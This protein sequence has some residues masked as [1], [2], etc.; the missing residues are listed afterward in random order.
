M[1]GRSLLQVSQWLLLYL[2]VHLPTPVLGRQVE[3]IMGTDL[4]TRDLSSEEIQTIELVLLELS[5][6]PINLNTATR[7]ILEQI[8]LLA[9]S[10]VDA[11][12]DFRRSIWG[13][14][15]LSGLKEIPG[16]SSGAVELLSAVGYVD[17]ET[18]SPHRRASSWIQM[19][20]LVKGKWDSSESSPANG[21]SR[22]RRSL[23][24]TG[25][26]R[27]VSWG[28]TLQNDPYEQFRWNPARGWYG[29]DHTSGYLT[30]GSDDS[31][32]VV[33]IGNF[34]VDA[35]QG[36]VHTRLFGTRLSAAS[37]SQIVRTWSGLRRYTG[38]SASSLRG[39]GVSA[40]LLTGLRLQAFFSRKA[41]D[42]RAD[43]ST[44]D[45]S[46]FFVLSGSGTHISEG[47]LSR[48]KILSSTVSGALIDWQIGLF[49]V[50]VQWS[51]NR[52]QHPVQEQGGEG[53]RSQFTAGSVYGMA[54]MNSFR[55]IGE[56]TLGGNRPSQFVLGITWKPTRSVRFFSHL[57][58]YDA[59]S[60]YRFGNPYGLRRS[61]NFQRG[62]TIG[63]TFR[64]VRD[65]SFSASLNY[66]AGSSAKEVA[67][68]SIVSSDLRLH[69]Q[70]KLNPASTIKFFL[71][72][73]Q[74][75]DSNIMTLPSGSQVRG[76][77]IERRWQASLLVTY[78]ISQGLTLSSRFDTNLAEN[79]FSQ[80]S[81]GVHTFQQVTLSLSPKLSMVFRYSLYSAPESGNRF[82]IY[83]PDM[84]GQ[85]SVPVLS[86]EGSRSLILLTLV[87]AT[88]WQ[89]Q[90][91]WTD[92]RQALGPSGT[93]FASERLA[94]RHVQQLSLQFAV[95]L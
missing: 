63:T 94:E 15:T 25:R 7:E 28:L 58:R 45:T 16:L 23:R 73:K 79:A 41:L 57:Y 39:I 77:G 43:S 75:Q 40:R 60:I 32:L 52:F 72:S 86:T 17:E 95:E 46:R 5:K 29:F 82:Y 93:L 88:Q 53:A 35:G 71:R 56:V 59:Q 30:W 12:L 47:Q 34:T 38:S 42:A 85:L 36:L 4:D 22:L 19:R 54:N 76:S 84:R 6:Q 21:G 80:S 11:L 66:S 3:T 1:N 64:P 81:S 24:M 90:V 67:F 18:S 9:G 27:N 70:G 50:G 26:V 68:F 33:T 74:A 91:K 48:R 83:E 65:W 69:L 2:F 20:A 89:L 78:S 14:A 8:P 92:M 31:P 61:L 55:L 51:I 13:L 10:D 49:R 44:T 87:P 37:P 62:V